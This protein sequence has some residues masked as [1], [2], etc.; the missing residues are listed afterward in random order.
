MQPN[1]EDAAA[2]AFAI[3]GIGFF[4]FIFA[5]SIFFVVCQWKIYE[6]AGEPGW[7]C[8]VP[9]YGAI[10]FLKIIGKPLWWLALILVPLVNLVGLF[11]WWF[12]G[13]H[14]LSKSFGKDIG[15]T[16]GLIF[17]PF[18]FYPIMAFDK[19]IVYQGNGSNPVNLDNQV[20]SIGT[21]AV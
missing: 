12:G 7:A 9:V 16:L 19:T 15:F 8:L 3:F 13:S 1:Y 17:L 11:I 6:K 2:G 10:V 21:P 14:A 20:D 5:I 4:M 18:I